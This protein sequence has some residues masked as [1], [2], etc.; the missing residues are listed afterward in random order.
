MLSGLLATPTSMMYRE[1]SVDVN[2]LMSTS[3]QA[4]ASVHRPSE[5]ADIR[6]STVGCHSESRAINVAI[7]S[8][9]MMHMGLQWRPYLPSKLLCGAC[10]VRVQHRR[11]KPDAQGN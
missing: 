4:E 7:R 6:T 8:K 3:C 9:G 1:C 5:T 11:E 2:T 10:G